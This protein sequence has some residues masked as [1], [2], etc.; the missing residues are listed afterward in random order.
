MHIGIA[1][2]ETK[3]EIRIVREVETATGIESGIEGIEIMTGTE[4]TGRIAMERGRTV[5]ETGRIVIER[6]RDGAAQ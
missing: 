3:A 5:M 1:R 6:G 2:T 4:E